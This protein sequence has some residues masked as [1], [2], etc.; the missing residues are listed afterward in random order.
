M[1][2]P[3]TSP[4]AGAAPLGRLH[5]A[6]EVVADEVRRF[7]IA[8]V[9]LFVLLTMFTLHEEIALRAH[10]GESRAIPFAPHGFA[11]VNALV[12]GKVALMVEN[13]RLGS[14]IRARPLIFPI[15][16]EAL[17]LAVLFVAMH[18][19]ESLIGGW[20]HGESLAKSVPAVAGG[21]AAGI[22]FAMF[23]FFVAMLPF[24]GFRQI[25][26]EIGWPRMREIL[27][28]TPAAKA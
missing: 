27:F 12:L 21:G 17:I 26:L 18:V 20:L 5:H 15:V 25:T 13:L 10:G 9:Y 24:C 16:F 7:L 6:K 14:R 23:S 4:E 22:A 28:G 3:T 19:L 1:T 11:L 2:T 8:A